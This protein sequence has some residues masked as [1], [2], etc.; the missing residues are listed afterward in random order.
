MNPQTVGE[1]ARVMS[2][3]TTML[4]DIAAEVAKTGEASRWPGP[5]GLIPGNRILTAGSIFLA[6]SAAADVRAAAEAAT[7]LV[8][9]LSVQIGEQVDASSATDGYLDGLI[10]KKQADE[11][12]DRVM[13]DP[14]ALDGMTPQQVAAWWS[15]L[16][17]D[18]QDTFVRDNHWVAGNT[19]GIPFDRRIEANQLSAEELLLGPTKLSSDQ[20]TYLEKVA[21]ITVGPNGEIDRH[22]PSKSLISFDPNADRIIEMVGDLN[23]GTTNIVNYVPGTTADMN[24]FYSESTQQ[25]GHAIVDGAVPPGSTVV[26]VY[27]DSPFPDFGTEGVYHSSWAGSVGGPYHDFNTA[28]GLENTGGA[29]VTSIEHSFGSSVGGYAETQGTHFDNR[30]VL[31]GIGMTDAWK[32]DSSTNYYSFTGPDD[33]IRLAR[34]QGSDDLNLGFPNPPTIES[35][36]TE[37]DTGF[38]DEPGPKSV[39]ELKDAAEHGIDQHTRVAGV[40]NNQVVI[41]GIQEILGGN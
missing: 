26:F 1:Q 3:Y 38:E 10:S 37:L 4:D 41:D 34:E 13:D 11:L 32:P 9:R 31:G 21:G 6:E 20:R 22:D 19:N 16:S 17:K 28:L 40:D 36:F 5:F 12:Y 8:G 29:A 25:M 39:W 14:G 24:G 30:I 18:Q 35:G 2:A 33:I 23:E 27:K 15:R 7:E